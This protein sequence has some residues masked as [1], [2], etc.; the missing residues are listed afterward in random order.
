MEIV[1]KAFEF[2]PNLMKRS[3]YF[4]HQLGDVVLPRALQK[5]GLGPVASELTALPFT[6]A[7]AATAL[8]VGGSNVITPFYGTLVSAVFNPLGLAV[9]LPAA[10]LFASITCVGIGMGDVLLKKFGKTPIFDGIYDNQAYRIERKQKLKD[11]AAK[12][13]AEAALEQQNALDAQQKA[14]AAAANPT[15][16]PFAGFETPAADGSQPSLAGARNAAAGSFIYVSASGDVVV[17]IF[18]GFPPSVDETQAPRE[19]PPRPD[20][21]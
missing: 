9:F 16:Q 6:A 1:R 4:G 20:K 7:G 12:A 21:P 5:V 19:R 15:G 11:K 18:A 10:L 14:P 17:P 3:M 8:W 2:I 13:K